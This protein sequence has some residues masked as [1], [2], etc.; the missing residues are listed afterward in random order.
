M[1]LVFEHDTEYASKLPFLAPLSAHVDI[2]G[3]GRRYHLTVSYNNFFGGMRWWFVLLFILPA[4]V[5]CNLLAV[6]LRNHRAGQL[7]AE[8]AAR[9]LQDS[10]N[11]F[12]DFAEVASDWFW[13]TDQ[14]NRFIYFSKQLREATGLDPDSL[15]GMDR[16]LEQNQDP[17]D[18]DWSRHIADVQ[19]FR[20]FKNFR[21]KATNPDGELLWVSISGKPVF[22]E[23]GAFA[24]YRGTGRN[25]TGE[26]EVKRALQ[27]SKEQAELANRAKSEFLANISHELRTPLNAIIGFSELITGQTFGPVGNPRYI[28]YAKDIF[29]SGQHL[30]ALINDILDLS[31]I[32]SGMEQLYEDPIDVAQML[33]SVARLMKPHAEAGEIRLEVLQGDDLPLLLADERKLKQILVNLLSNAIKFTEAGGNVTVKASRNTEGS[34]VFHVSDTGIGMAEDDIP[35]AFSQFVQIDSALNRRFNGTGLGLPLTKAL[36][37]QHGGEVVLKSELGVGTVVT[38]HFPPERSIST[39]APTLD[40]VA[41]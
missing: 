36:I 30:L 38:F 6:I 16:T 5:A 20:P 12:R 34:L 8:Q 31:K 24:G 37:E 22:D 19:S 27:S 10:K 3:Q 41:G 1:G 13:A 40:A 15:I 21:Y 26:T 25:V 39:P 18:D 17:D 14:N 33:R 4:I 9:V 7:Q 28:D 29:E 35:K 23:D 32:E 2:V 11:Q